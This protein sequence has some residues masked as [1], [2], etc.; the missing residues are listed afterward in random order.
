VGLGLL[1]TVIM[2]A[3]LWRQRHRLAVRLS[4]ALVVI[5]LVLFTR[6]EHFEGLGPV[7]C[8]VLPGIQ[9]IRV[10]VRMAILLLIPAGLAVA[11]LADGGRSRRRHALSLVLAL[12]CCVEQLGHRASFEAGERDGRVNSIRRALPDG[13]SAFYLA[14][15]DPANPASLVHIDAMWASLLEGVPTVNGYSGA[16][17]TGF[18]PLLFEGVQGSD[19]T[20]Q[21][22]Q[23]LREWTGRYR[24]SDVRVEWIDLRQHQDAVTAQA[25]STSLMPL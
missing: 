21:Q 12:F 20:L 10:M 19:Q 9:G 23:A 6:T 13:A 1:T 3:F 8:H 11:F 24:L 2:V 17:P 22:K 14:R 15:H 25:G 5:S 7:L 18:L 16:F 4:L